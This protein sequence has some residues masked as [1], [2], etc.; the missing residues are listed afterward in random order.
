M[1]DFFNTADFAALPDPELQSEFYDDVPAK[2]LI[3]WIIDMVIVIAFLIAVVV[4]TLGLSIF[5]A[6]FLFLVLGFAYRVVTLANGSATWG[7]RLMS[8][9]L[10][11]ADGQ[12]LE[13][14]D[15]VLH[16]LG[17]SLSMSF[18]PVQIASIVMMLINPRKQGLS[19]MLLG[20]VMIN[21]GARH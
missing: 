8:I 17:Y 11:R 2:R 16:T 18:F 3:A 5:F 20:T 21:K 1:S 7:M 13:T 14:G 15:A 9:E 19:D 12:R 10:R 6:G 4:L